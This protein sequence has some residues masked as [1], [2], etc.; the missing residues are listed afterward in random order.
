MKPVKK[1]QIIELKIEGLVFGGKG[2]SRVN[3]Y[4]I[5]INNV[6]PGQTVTARIVKTRS[7]FAEATLID[8]K[9]KSDME[10]TPRC[11]YFHYCGGCK[12][13]NIKYNAQV[14]FL[15]AQVE[16]VYRRVG[17]IEGI[18]VEKVLTS[19]KTFRY[20][21][22]MEFA[23]S[24]RR[25]KPEPGPDE[26]EEPN[27]ALGLRAPNDYYKAI[28]IDDCLIAP[29]ES[30]IILKT[31]RDFCLS[32]GLEA[33]DQK[34]H[35]GLLRHLVV[36]KGYKTDEI[37]VNLIINSKDKSWI[38]TFEK[39]AQRLAKNVASLK[40][41]I[42]SFYTGL[43]GV[44]DF[45]EYYVL[46]GRDFIEEKIFDLTF[47]ISPRSFFQTNS[48]MVETLYQKAIEM[49]ELKADDVVWDLYCGTGSISLCVARHVSRVYGFELVREA[50]IDAKINAE[51]NKISNVEF[52]ECNLDRFFRTNRSFLKEVPHPDVLIL[53]PPRA[54]MHPRL[55]M[56]VAKISPE[57]IVYI[58]CNPATQ[59]RDIKT[60]IEHGK[61]TIE[62]IQPVDMFP[63]TP[64][65]EVVTTLNK[66]S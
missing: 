10:T 43:A 33:Y 66:R 2:I 13:Q 22:K 35:E 36:R 41:F 51:A 31:V 55:V 20:R 28:D 27:F 26:A 59:A 6:V 17:N 42:L 15:R 1:G 47:R 56:D 34:S 16:D 62:K 7:T 32:E 39:L 57:K 60:L 63:H 4:V 50:I 64:H 58:S 61:Y 38:D 48:L 65:V 12:H 19:K 8:V 3:G 14:E 45:E 46:L 54:G 21:N 53:D 44:A 25:L 5:F 23:F 29:E 37:M 40:S 30:G 9:E 52:I 49:A 24:N 11:K 18:S